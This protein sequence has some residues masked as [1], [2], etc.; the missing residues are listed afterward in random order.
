MMEGETMTKQ[1]LMHCM[2]F[3]L[4][5]AIGDNLVVYVYPMMNYWV[6]VLVTLLDFVQDFLADH[7]TTKFCTWTY[8]YQN[9]GY[10]HRRMWIFL[11]VQWYQLGVWWSFLFHLKTNLVIHGKMIQPIT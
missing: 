6:I 11:G 4:R 2:L 10:F 8:L 5:K 1:Y 9:E 3:L 7:I